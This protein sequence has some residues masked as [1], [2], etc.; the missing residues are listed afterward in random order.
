[1][2][3]FSSLEKYLFIE[4]AWL[5]EE[6]DMRSIARRAIKEPIIRV[7]TSMRLI[8]ANFRIFGVRSF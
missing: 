4:Y 7:N 5:A 6:T 3:E 2:N 8:W 1:M